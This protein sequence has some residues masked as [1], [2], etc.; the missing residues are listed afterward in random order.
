MVGNKSSDEPKIIQPQNKLIWAWERIVPRLDILPLKFYQNSQ[1]RISE[2]SVQWLPNA[3]AP[4]VHHI[5]LINLHWSRA[6]YVQIKLNKPIVWKLHDSWAREDVTYQKYC[7]SC[8]QIATMT[9][10]Y[11]TWQ[12][13]AKAWNYQWFIS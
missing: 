12:R 10:I 1:H 11:L 13:K 5:E 2:Y 8:F 6:G 4:Q 7:R 3:I 9:R